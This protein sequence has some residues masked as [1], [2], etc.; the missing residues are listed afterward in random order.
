MESSWSPYGIML[1]TPQRGGHVEWTGGG[2]KF[3]HLAGASLLGPPAVL[4]QSLYFMR[5]LQRSV[6][7]YKILS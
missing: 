5:T 2:L 6:G 1:E 4:A 7:Q 3:A